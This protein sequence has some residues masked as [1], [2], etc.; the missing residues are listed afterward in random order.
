MKYFKKAKKYVIIGGNAL[1]GA[2]DFAEYSKFASASPFDFSKN[3]SIGCGGSAAI[4]FYP[5][6]VAELTALV[7]KLEKDEIPY[8][9]LG[10]L[11]NVLPPD[12]E[13]RFAVVST[14]KLNGVVMGELVFVY[15][16]ATS[17]ALLRACKREKKSGAEFLSGVPCTLGGA[18]YMNAGAGGKYISE[19]VENVL[20]LR[21]G[22]RRIL[23][24]KDCGYSYKKSVFME[25][26]DI[27]L[28][29]T[30]HLE[31]ATAGQIEE[32]EKYYLDR[33]KGL[34]KGRSMGCVFKNPV[35]AYAGDLIERSGLKGFRIGGAKISEEHANFIINERNATAK[36]IRALITLAK[37]A[38]KSQYGIELK[39]EI[40]Y[41]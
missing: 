39:E 15:A 2:F 38:V 31:R 36:D 14:K 7:E 40:R 20:L 22:E 18:L 23:P 8:Y 1:N 35:S 13:S 12:G 6:S 3:S 4:A 9:V 34:P 33:R 32:R 28:G 27:L 17:G 10:N 30:L 25:N 21:K 11:T 29:A 5:S 41:L 16:G 19:I 26:G 24:V 37:N